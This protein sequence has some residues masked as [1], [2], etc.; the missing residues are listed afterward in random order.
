MRQGYDGN[1]HLTYCTNIHPG[2]GW[3]EV[4]ANLQHY[5][6]ALK[7]RLAPSTT[8]GVG[9]RLSGR[10]SSELL[11]DHALPQF[12]AFLQRHGLYVFTLNGFPY[13][14]F[15]QQPIK[16]QVHA[17]DWR[18]EE[19]V[20]YTLRLVKILA[21][22]LPTGLEGSISTSPLSYKA[23][24][25]DDDNV[26]W[27]L[28][29]RNIVRIAEALVQVQRQQG[30]LI[31]LDIEPE[32][33]G[34]LENSE[35][36]VQFYR[37][38]LLTGGVHML[39]E[40]LQVSQDEAHRLL[41][42]HIRVCFDTCHVALAYEEPGDILKRFAELGIQI[43]KVQI[44]SAL[45]V[46][47]P[48]APTEIGHALQP[49]A[50]STYLHQVVQRN[51]DGSLY[52]YPDLVDALPHLQ[53]AGIAQWRIHFHVPIFI[54]RF[55]TFLSTQDTILRTLALLREKHFSRHLEIETYTWS[56]LPPEL[57]QALIDSIMQEYEW[58]QQHLS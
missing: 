3:N 58:V 40:A 43:G 14:P 55:E 2:N 32:P 31:H 45:K 54:D 20:N 30:K 57:K 12:Q 25:K 52:H 46:P 23:W 5:T 28:F 42:E 56:V 34:L 38:W 18:D 49:F 15:H 8:F 50:E 53:N 27:A 11:S 7:A 21:Q 37:R 9:L 51:Q 41:L 13:G 36:V 26:S 44:S 1:F 10:E 19:R 24:V 48:N 29:T 47:F 6:L 33:D 4:F 39:A 16:A 17:P 35:E 22:L